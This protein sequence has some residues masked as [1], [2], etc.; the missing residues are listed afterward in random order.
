MPGVITA[1]LPQQKN[2][3]RISVYL[4]GRYAF[5]L[6]A[7]VGA[8]L[9]VGQ[10]LSVE[11]INHLQERDEREVAYNRALGFLTY[12]PRSRAEL[13]LY[14]KRKAVPPESRE[15]VLDRLSQAGLLDDRAFATYWVENRETFRPRGV[16]ALRAE[17]R[18]KGVQDADAR[19]A[20]EAIDETESA[21]RAAL[22]RAQRLCRLDNTTF[23]RR[24][25]GFLQRRGFGYDVVKG[26]VD[27]L[28]RELRSP[29][30]GDQED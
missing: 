7:L 28:W 25:G 23:R 9:R 22:S 20:A 6:E 10:L 27:R 17:L 30:D 3:N 16:R 4:D 26:T 14:L 12:R 2:E 5:G 29:A 15:V 18:G 24:L 8:A 19:K 13:D 1:L 11:E 21:Y